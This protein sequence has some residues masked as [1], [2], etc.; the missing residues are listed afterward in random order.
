MT[1]P[2]TSLLGLPEE[3]LSLILE[4]YFASVE[5]SLWHWAPQN[6]DF[7]RDDHYHPRKIPTSFNV[8]LSCKTLHRLATGVMFG[9][10]TVKHQKST[11][12]DLQESHFAVPFHQF[13]HIELDNY[14]PELHAPPIPH[15]DTWPW[16]W[17]NLRTMKMVN[18]FGGPAQATI[19]RLMCP[20]YIFYSYL[21]VLKLTLGQC[22]F[23]ANKCTKCCWRNV[24]L[25]T[26]SS[27]YAYIFH[28]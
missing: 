14:M 13:K 16:N 10:M 9:A 21:V 3:I 24:I 22:L 8:L 20:S 27:R 18:K 7:S 15:Q 1:V 4:T 12:A 25:T 28:R 19:K 5:I 6:D 23:N 2:A 26:S 11:W 17:S